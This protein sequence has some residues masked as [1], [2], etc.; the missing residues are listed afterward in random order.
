M[1]DACTGVGLGAGGGGSGTPGPPN[2]LSLSD[3]FGYAGLTGAVGI[4]GTGWTVC[5]G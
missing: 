5:E 3:T 4:A 2:E 1:A